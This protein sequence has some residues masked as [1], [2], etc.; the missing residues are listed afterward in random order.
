MD[1]SR[2][3]NLIIGG[4]T[5]ILL[6]LPSQG[7]SSNAYFLDLVDARAN[8]MVE[9]TVAQADNPSAVYFNPAGIVQLPGN[10]LSTGLTFVYIPSADFTSNGTSVFG[11]A[12]QETDTKT[13]QSYIPSFFVTHKINDALSVGF[14]SFTNFG[15]STRWPND[16]EG[17]YISG[18]TYSEIKTLALNP[19][20]AYRPNQKISF[21]GGIV[22]QNAE[23]KSQNKFLMG[24]G[25]PDASVKIDAKD[26]LGL[27]YNLGVLTWLSDNVK[28]G[29]SYRSAIRQK[30]E[31]DFKLYGTPGGAY[32]AKDDVSTTVTLPAR[33]YSGLSYTQGPLTVEGDILLTQWSS[34]DESIVKFGKLPTSRAM[35]D[36]H[37]AL[38]YRIGADYSIT[39]DIDIRGGVEYAGNPIP[40]GSEEPAVPTNNRWRIGTGGG[41][42]FG[43]WAVDLSYNYIFWLNKKAFNN[44]VGDYNASISPG[45]GKVTGDFD[46]AAHVLVTTISYKF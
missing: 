34:I 39:K 28:L 17:R 24:A 25:V 43:D 23:I 11:K 6:L 22:L 30:L 31:G 14:G 42:K 36:Y 40:L 7:F 21:S 4:F 37:D 46:L 29:L 44:S 20:V 45:L 8:G 3:T 9:S 16:W 18:G 27:G 38:S 10:Q 35:K 1:C 26:D 15:L 2:T 12:G 19:V 5:A 33:V 32:N 13:L 41:Y